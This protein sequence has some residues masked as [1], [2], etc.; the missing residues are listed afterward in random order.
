MNFYKEEIENI[1]KKLKTTELGLTTSD[2]KERIVRYGKNELP[3][4]K[5]DGIIKIF[6]RQLKDPIVLILI[7]TIIFSFLV[8][9]VLDAFAVIFIVLID[10]VM[11][12]IQEYSAVKKAMS[13]ENIIK[14]KC[15]VLRDDKEMIID[16][17]E[18]VIGD[19]VFLE[20]GNKISADIRIIE[21][22]NLTIDES[23]LTG[24]SLAVHK[25]SEIM[26][27]DALVSERTN[28]VYAGCVVLTGR[29]IGVVCKTGINTEIGQ[30]AKS[31]TET[32]DEKSPLTIRIEKF[33]KQISLIVLVLAF[34][35]TI[36]LISKTN[37]I[38]E[39]FMSV[40]AL[41]ISALP[42]GLPLALTMAL[43]IAS[44]RML[45]ENVIVKKLNS[46]ESLG[47]C[48]LIASDK[49]G[50]LTVNEQTAKMIVL[51]N[52]KTYEVT[53]SG[54]NINGKVIINDEKDTNNILD[55][56]K[57][58]LINN[59]ANLEIHEDF[60]EYQGDSIDVAFLVLARK[61]NVLD[62]DIQ[63]I[64]QIPY[65]SFNKYSA[66]FYKVKGDNKVYATVKGS[67]ETVTNFSNKM[68]V[69]SK[70]VKMDFNLIKDQNE[71]LA[72]SGYRVIALSCG[73]IK[74]KDNYTEDDLCDLTF[75]G[76]VGFIDPIRE[77]C[78]ESIQK[79]MDAS[80]KVVMITGDHPLTA[81]KIAS[82]LQIISTKK[83]IATSSE[84]DKKLKE[85]LL[86][87][88]EFIKTKKVFA[89][90]TPLQKL[91]IVN[92]FK[93]QG[94]FV[95]VTG[96]GV[97]DAPA[98]KTANIV[99]SMESGTDVS[100]ETANMILTNDK[101][102]SIVKG[103]IEGRCAYSNIRKVTYMLISCGL[104]EVLFFVLAIILNFPMPLVAI[105][106]L[107][108]NIVTD[109][110]QDLALSFE[111][112]ED[113]IMDFPPRSPKENLFDK[114]LI[115]E[116]LI[117][118]LTIGVVVFIVWYYLI[119]ILKFDIN[120][121]RGYIMALMVFM[122]NMHVLNCRSETKSIFSKKIKRNKFVY[123][124]IAFAIILQF[125]IMEVPF[126]SQFLKTES[127]PLIHLI[128]LFLISLIVLF[129]MEMYKLFKYKD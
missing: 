70:K 58:G 102:S 15:K 93:R 10:L 71:K 95:A 62:N 14:V 109:G 39:V 53:G 29:A 80:V 17:S 18:L 50:T 112:A 6:L 73:E 77:D 84:V 21:A 24:E 48:T 55:L 81:Y 31:V 101:F 116:V 124:S 114:T 69:D 103:I 40:I 117:S 118:G 2:A 113:D 34:I 47:S 19:I 96:D 51:P 9:E 123:I 126:M 7:I 22:V 119:E 122:Q 5:S 32:K 28:M 106:I 67:L 129:V 90:V 4:K 87:F 45:K 99:I 91:E 66:V 16:S 61:M 64:S 105:Q 104:A 85:G 8:G 60:V 36:L 43:T 37:Q 57:L 33:S 107:W 65:E 3:K 27:Q 12:T 38:N 82:D 100:L 68:L 97:N 75:L 49:T 89:R 76:L 56:I 72:S 20:S 120:V 13:L 42:E 115:T 41:T 25:N 111:R 59:E 44:N 88:D 110:L 30:I 54:Y 125:I 46:V 127:I 92:S 26:N 83:E 79:C 1:L 52:S 74:E 63:I 108:L 98:L 128:I 35:L 23:I 121:S 78:K 86:S 94:E 11:G